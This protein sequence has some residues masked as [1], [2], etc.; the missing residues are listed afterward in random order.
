[1]D[2]NAKHLRDLAARNEESTRVKLELADRIKQIQE[3]KGNL[4]QSEQQLIEF[5]HSAVSKASETILK[6]EEHRSKLEDLVKENQHVYA[7]NNKLKSRI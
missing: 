7:E 2:E 5:H 4:K 3:L 1:M 6:H